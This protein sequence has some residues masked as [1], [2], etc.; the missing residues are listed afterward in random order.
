MNLTSSR[1]RPYWPTIN[2]SSL[3]SFCAA[4]SSRANRALGVV[5]VGLRIA[6]IN[7]HAVAHIF[8]DETVET[9]NRL[10]RAA[11]IGADYL[12]QLFGIESRR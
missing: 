8:G 10:R 4:V 12:A 5:L 1:G 3:S 2:A 11:V 6:E 7:Q 9:S